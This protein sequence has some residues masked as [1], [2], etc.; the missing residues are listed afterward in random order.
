MQPKG[1]G[2]PVLHIQCHGILRWRH[3]D[4]IHSMLASL[5]ALMVLGQLQCDVLGVL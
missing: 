4:L 2:A 1:F 5:V 3:Y